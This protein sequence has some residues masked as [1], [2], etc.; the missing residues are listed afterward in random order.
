MD[1]RLVFHVLQYVAMA[2]SVHIV[3]WGVDYVYYNNC[4]SGILNSLYTHQSS[5]CKNMK[6]LSNTL[7][8]SFNTGLLYITYT[9]SH[10]LSKVFGPGLLH[11]CKLPAVV[12]EKKCI[13]NSDQNL[14]DQ[15][16]QNCEQN[17]SDH[18]SL[19]PECR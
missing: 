8:V 18:T 9:I 15:Q 4:S 14:T 16:C 7:D 19:V 13:H 2:F 5:I 10:L 11:P 12:G 1:T 17:Q 3:I 6:T